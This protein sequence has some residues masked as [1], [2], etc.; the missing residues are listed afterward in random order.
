MKVCFFILSYLL[1]LAA[2]AQS[3]QPN[4]LLIC[5][6]DLRPELASFG[7][8]YIHS[9]NMDKLASAGRSF[10]R[11]YVQAPTCGASRYALLTGQYGAADNGALFAR[12][13]KLKANPQAVTPSMPAW[14]RQHG[15]TTIAIGKVSHH[16]GGKAG[17]NWDDPE[18]LE[19]PLSWDRNSMPAGSWQHPRGAMHGL[20]NGEIRKRAGDTDVY[21][22]YAGDDMSYPDGLIR[23][24]AVAELAALANQDQPFFLAVGFIRPHLPFGA[25]KK[26][27]D[28][29]EKVKLPPIPHPKKPQGSTTWHRSGEFMKYNRWD[30][31]PN[32]NPEFATE[33]RRYYAACVSYVDAQIG[34]LLVE[35][36]RTGLADNTIIVV[37]GD[38]GWHLGEHAIWGKH[39]LFDESLRSP[40]IIKSPR[41]ISDAG[42]MSDAIV[43]SIDIYP[44]LCELAGLEIPAKIDGESL[45]VHLQDPGAAG[46]YALSN[47]SSGVSTVITDNYRL[48]AHGHSGPFELYDHDSPEKET[49]NIASSNPAMVS[50]LLDLIREQHPNSLKKAAEN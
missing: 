6:D 49:A 16:P 23:R 22:A 8:Q 34:H 45:L 35:L 33:V 17:K 31:N 39:S 1:V 30:Q 24:A 10:S 13:N 46:T 14:F 37:W 36:K 40:L 43:E 28:L 29:Y 25:P 19:M 26:Y 2:T 20:A 41:G 4:I 50:E 48:I 5:V 47:R 3:Q 21:Q 18:K 11:H 12:A 27:L 9:P 38:H 32:Q 42:R 44:T 15:Y 7:K